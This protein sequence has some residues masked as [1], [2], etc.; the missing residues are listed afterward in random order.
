MFVV[1][2]G[3]RKQTCIRTYVFIIR[4][5]PRSPIPSKAGSWMNT[6]FILNLARQ[7]QVSDWL[8]CGFVSES[9]PSAEPP[10]QF[11]PTDRFLISQSKRG[12]D[13]L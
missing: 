7:T 10:H 11:I 4:L 5:T 8:N 2:A 12:E 1:G 13:V 6:L 3:A 9:D